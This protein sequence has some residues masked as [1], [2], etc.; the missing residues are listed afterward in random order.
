MFPMSFHACSTKS[1]A[2]D[3]TVSAEFTLEKSLLENWETRA[4]RKRVGIG[5]I[6]KHRHVSWLAPHHW[7]LREIA[8]WDPGNYKPKRKRVLLTNSHR[9][10]VLDCLG[11][12]WIGPIFPLVRDDA[13]EV[14]NLSIKYLVHWRWKLWGG[15]DPTNPL[16][17]N[18]RNAHC[19]MIHPSDSSNVKSSSAVY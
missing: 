15:S 7:I 12:G 11:G 10:T 8:C 14:K 2:A 1:F 16:V 5:W 6:G 9:K 13:G 3:A 18:L 19:C 4:I 17:F